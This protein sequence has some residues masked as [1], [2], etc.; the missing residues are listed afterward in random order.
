MV[1]PA[2]SNLTLEN[3]RIQLQFNGETGALVQV[4]LL[5]PQSSN[6]RPL[7][8]TIQVMTYG[9]RPGDAKK[10]QKSGAYIFLPDEPEPKPW[11]GYGK[12][13]LRITTG[14]LE[15]RYELICTEPLPI[16]IRFALQRGRRSVDLHSE[17]QLQGLYG[18]NKELLLRFR[19]PSID[20]SNTFYTDLNGLQMIS[21]KR[22]EK[23]PVQGN[24]YPLN[25]I[26]FIESGSEEG[27]NLRFNLL[28]AQPLGV[29]S[30]HS[31]TLDVFLDRRLTQDDARGLNQGVTDNKRTRESFRLLFELPTAPASK[32][33]PKLTSAALFES[34]SLLNPLLGIT[35]S[36]ESSQPLLPQP[37]ASF[38]QHSLPCDL[39]LLNIRRAT[40]RPKEFGLLLH[41]IAY[42]CDSSCS[43]AQ[44][45][46]LLSSMFHESVLEQFDSDKG[47][48][49][50]GISLLKP[51]V[52]EEDAVAFDQKLTV[53]PMEIVAFKLFLKQKSSS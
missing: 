17:F 21:R 14:R 49:P 52:A 47:L 41:R 45:P 15:S 27:T 7:E 19:V 20:N 12:P 25:T 33:D 46:I 42:S 18:A 50:H 13:K 32:K 38:L 9:T 39:H 3:E 34:H 30:S 1:T 44:E 28:T 26:A 2:P 48:Q 8:A 40:R 10:V 23:I 35:P 16:Q 51:L 37:H 29:I 36:S 6:W 53:D 24:V 43:A 5:D 31:G 22:Y 11:S 4:S